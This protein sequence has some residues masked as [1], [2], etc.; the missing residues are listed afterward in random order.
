MVTL[1]QDGASTPHIPHAL[2]V[3]GGL[4]DEQMIHLHHPAQ[5]P[6]R[7]TQVPANQPRDVALGEDHGLPAS[8]HVAQDRPREGPLVLPRLGCT[9]RPADPVKPGLE[10]AGPSPPPRSVDGRC[11]SHSASTCDA[12]YPV[13]DRTS[14]GHD[15]QCTRQP[16]PCCPTSSVPPLLF[17]RLLDG[18]SGKPQT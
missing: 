8:I 3:D 11:P 17:G 18:P 2:A 15:T 9:A 6:L 4:A 5:H 12:A 1:N 16:A 7:L 13:Q 10:F 14:F